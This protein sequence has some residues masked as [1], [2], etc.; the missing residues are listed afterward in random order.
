MTKNEIINIIAKKRLVEDIVR[1]IA[2]KEDDQLNDLVQDIY[3]SLMEKDEE[4]IVK[5]YEDNQLRFFVTRMVINNIRSKNSPFWC[6]Y[7]K[8]TNNM[9]ELGEYEDEQ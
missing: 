7:K 5:L 1:N 3:V 4:K 9:N 6:N 2:K 8:F